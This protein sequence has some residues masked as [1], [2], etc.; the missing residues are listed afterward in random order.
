MA[1]I[2]NRINLGII[3]LYK[4]NYAS[5]FHIRKIAKLIGTSHVAILPHL[6]ELENNNILQSK[7]TG[8]NK[9][10]SLVLKNPIA[11]ELISISEKKFTIELINKDKF[12]ES[13][14]KELHD[15]PGCMIIFSYKKDDNIKMMY[16]GNLEELKYKK[17]K[18]IGQ[19]FSKRI[20]VLSGNTIQFEKELKKQSDLIKNIINDHIILAN[21]DIFVNLMYKYYNLS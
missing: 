18:E 11:K 9:I 6:K 10:Y 3:G 15:L 17:I 5:S 20:Q 16:I 13:L 1:E 19:N 12:I 8:R 2:F 4:N 7:I 21:Q 14:Y